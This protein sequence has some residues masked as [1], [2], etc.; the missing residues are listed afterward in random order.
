[1]Y[2][3]VLNAKPSPDGSPE[4]LYWTA[5]SLIMWSTL[6]SPNIHC[7]V[8]QAETAIEC[9]DCP[10]HHPA[11][12]TAFAQSK[13]YTSGEP[14][15]EGLAFNNYFSTSPCPLHRSHHQQKWTIRS[16]KQHQCNLDRQTTH[17]PCSTYILAVRTFAAVD[18]CGSLSNFIYIYHSSSLRYLDSTVT[19][20]VS[21]IHLHHHPVLVNHH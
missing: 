16:A 13:M 18:S 8:L 11:H 21:T 3:K 14:S 10:S 15:G 9:V 12:C 17:P 19:C 20:R 5:A 7:G 6:H 4:H 2:K 1:M